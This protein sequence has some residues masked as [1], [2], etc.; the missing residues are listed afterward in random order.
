M[1]LILFCHYNV[2]LLYYG[3]W[4]LLSCIQTSLSC[5]INKFKELNTMGLVIN[6]WT[7]KFW[8]FCLRFFF[9]LYFSCLFINID[10]SSRPG[11]VILYFTRFFR[12]PYDFSRIHSILSQPYTKP[13]TLTTIFYSIL[14]QIPYCIPF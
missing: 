13:K 6:L 5:R 4:L 14:V 9:L 10:L 3:V 8:C 2:C 7:N 11:V 1:S 12:M